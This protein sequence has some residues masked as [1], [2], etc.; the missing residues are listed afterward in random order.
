M[1][2]SARCI[3]AR[4]VPSNRRTR[5]WW[6]ATTECAIFAMG[7]FR[8]KLTKRPGSRAAGLAMTY[9]LIDAAQRVRVRSTHRIW[10][11]SCGSRAV[12]HKGNCSNDPPTSRRNQHRN[13]K[14]QPEQRSSEIYDPQVLMR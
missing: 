9:K 2:L 8:T 11:C 3:C 6:T 14:I 10:L 5:S 1:R 12:F 4:R 13:K 7:R